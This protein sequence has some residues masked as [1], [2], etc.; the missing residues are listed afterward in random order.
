M[1]LLFYAYDDCERNSEFMYALVEFDENYLRKLE[2][3]CAAAREIQRDRDGSIYAIEFWDQRARWFGGDGFCLT[4]EQ[5]NALSGVGWVVWPSGPPLT[6]D[7][8]R[9]D[10]DVVACCPDGDVCWSS[11][12]KHS[13]IRVNTL[14]ISV[15]ELRELFAKVNA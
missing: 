2:N 15:T 6:V 7:D 10:C 9:T 14:S 1:H 8:L 5:D 4:E 13:D 11:T 3:R 12:G